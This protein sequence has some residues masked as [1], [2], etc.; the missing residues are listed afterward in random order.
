MSNQQRKV[1]HDVNV[2]IYIPHLTEYKKFPLD[3]DDVTVQDVI[4]ALIERHIMSPPID[5]YFRNSFLQP[6]NR[7]S[8]YGI[9]EGSQLVAINHI[10]QK[11]FIDRIPNTFN[12]RMALNDETTRLNDLINT[13]NERNFSLNRLLKDKE[14]KYPLRK[15]QRTPT[16]Y[17][18]P[19][20]MCSS[21]IQVNWG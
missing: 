19:T 5:L 14:D 13:Q 21:P 18:K 20:E 3:P 9:T 8:F 12:E 17:V 15:I 7:L 1:Y 4:D 2:Y 16:I 11:K 10:K 6:S